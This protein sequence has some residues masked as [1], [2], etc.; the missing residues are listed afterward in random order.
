ME[1]RIRIAAFTGTRKG[2]TEAQKVAVKKLLEDL[3][4]THFQHGAA[5][6]ADEEASFVARDLGL[7]VTGYPGNISADRSK[8][9]HADFWS[10]E[11]PP[12]DRNKKL[13]DFAHLLI[14]APDGARRR[15][16]TW[17]TVDYARG[18]KKP[19]WLVSPDGGVSE[20]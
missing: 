20:L 6:G 18:K 1:K 12:L 13:V 2:M 5:V 4:I 9:A 10:A 3:A 8:T 14:A 16:G 7:K 19:V 15:S 17:S 11:A